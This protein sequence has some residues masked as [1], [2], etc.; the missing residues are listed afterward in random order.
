MV[1]Y[2]NEVN[3]G[4]YMESQAQRELIYGGK[5]VGLTFNPSGNEEVQAIKESAANFIDGIAGLSREKLKDADGEVIAM[6]KLVQRAA[7]EA[8]MW[9]VKA[10]TWQS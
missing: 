2:Y 8:Q 1:V 10:A 6:R 5:A 9:A 3:K 4:F 7:Q